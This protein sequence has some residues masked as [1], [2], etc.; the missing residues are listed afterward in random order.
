MT[1]RERALQNILKFDFVGGTEADDGDLPQDVMW[2]EE[3]RSHEVW[4]LGSRELATEK[5]L[6]AFSPTPDS[7]LSQHQMMPQNCV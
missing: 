4:R 6:D 2:D 7:I 5:R 1:R 3:L